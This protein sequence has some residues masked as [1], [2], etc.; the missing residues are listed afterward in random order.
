[1]ERRGAATRKRVIAGV[2]IFVAGVT[3]SVA[4]AKL[5]LIVVRPPVLKE[6]VRETVSTSGS[7][8]VGIVGN[9]PANLRGGMDLVVGG[10][11]PSDRHICVSIERSSGLYLAQFKVRRPAGQPT[12]RIRLEKSV[13]SKISKNVGEFAIRARAFEDGCKNSG[14]LLPV[15]W[16]GRNQS[17][18]TGKIHFLINS[19]QANSITMV[20]SS[21]SSNKA[22][23]RRLRDAMSS[24]QLSVRN[25]DTVCEVP[26]PTCNTTVTYKIYRRFGR[27]VSAPEEVSVRGLC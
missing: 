7:A 2:V 11:E 25:F 23:C 24:P 1:M 13:L 22:I 5:P 8:V 4:I 9:D 17:P 3:A 10:L 14:P 15:S 19:L 18:E 26:A 21:S 12:V 27:D 20:G 6:T 16:V